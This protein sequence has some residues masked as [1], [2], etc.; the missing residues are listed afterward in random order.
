[1]GF[2]LLLNLLQSLVRGHLSFFCRLVGA[3]TAIGDYNAFR[4]ANVFRHSQCPGVNVVQRRDGPS[5]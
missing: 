3:P 1:M 2:L 5:E 4:N